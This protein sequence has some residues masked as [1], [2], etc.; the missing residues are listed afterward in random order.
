MNIL[1]P[2]GPIGAAEKPILIVSVGIM[3][4]I[5]LPT[6]VPILAFSFWFR[7]SN[8]TAVCR[9]DRAHSGRIEIAVWSILALTIILLGGA[10]WIGAPTRP[11]KG[12]RRSRQAADHS[13]GVTRLE[14]A[15]HLSRPENCNDQFPHGQRQ[16]GSNF[17]NPGKAEISTSDTVLLNNPT[18]VR[19]EDLHEL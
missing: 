17:S 19:Q 13:G 7:A 2:R 8:T 10:A 15:V 9:P 6:I 5:V 12:A 4:A 16:R 18:A 1:D 14:M 11:G 3:L